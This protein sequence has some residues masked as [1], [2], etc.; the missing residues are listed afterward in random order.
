MGFW[1]SG[2]LHISCSES[3][4]YYSSCRAARTPR[5]TLSPWV[6]QCACTVYRGSATTP[7]WWCGGVWCGVGVVGQPPD[8][9]MRCSCCWS[10]SDLMLAISLPDLMLARPRHTI[11]LHLLTPSL[12]T[13]SLYHVVAHALLYS[14]VLLCIHSI[15]PVRGCVCTGY[16]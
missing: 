14:A 4:S 15:L 11:S 9:R 1:D 2:N 16:R 12:R 7:Y 6:V 5:S 10:T 13:H 8:L 3:T